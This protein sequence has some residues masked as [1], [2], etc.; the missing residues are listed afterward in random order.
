MQELFGTYRGF[1]PTDESDVGI[2][3]IQI[4]FNANSLT[5]S[6]ATGLEI[7]TDIIP[8]S[9]V[10][11]LTDE[12]IL[13]EM[14]EGIVLP[15]GTRGFMLTESGIKLIF[16]MKDGEQNGVV[17]T[18]MM[19]DAILGPTF[20]FTPAQVDAGMFDKAV[21]MLEGHYGTIGVTPMIA[22]GGLAPNTVTAE[23]A[24]T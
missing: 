23:N 1:T 21:Q 2:G 13:M 15:A 24:S 22:H 14:Q 4:I 5:M 10:R 19:S 6:M 8:M 3:E 18:G 7:L 12:E 11:E 9:E 20:A 17:V 16:V